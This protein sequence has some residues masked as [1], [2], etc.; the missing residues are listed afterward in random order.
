MKLYLMTDVEGVAGVL[1]F[2][3]WTGPGKLHY[4]TARA[5]IRAGALRAMQRAK[6]EDFGLIP[7]TPPL[8][9]P[10]GGARLS[11]VEA[12]P[13]ERVTKFRPS[14]N[15][16]HKTISKA[17]RPPPARSAPVTPNTAAS[18]SRRGGAGISPRR[19]RVLPRG[20]FR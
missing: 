1:N 7:L 4:Q 3:E 8:D 12:P 5:R 16:P 19:S 9:F 18:R 20:R 2:Q 17:T 10:R 14:E 11:G 6:E 13:F 15:Q